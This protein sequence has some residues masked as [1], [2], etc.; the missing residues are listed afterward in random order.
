MPYFTENMNML[1]CDVPKNYSEIYIRKIVLSL[2]LTRCK[3]A[4]YTE[5][6]RL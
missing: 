5:K 3:W 6:G 2:Q 1:N 4:I